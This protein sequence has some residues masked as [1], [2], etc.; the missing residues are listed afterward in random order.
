VTWFKDRRFNKLVNTLKF[1]YPLMPSTGQSSAD[2]ASVGLLSSELR[3]LTPED[4]GFNYG[5]LLSRE[6]CIESVV[7]RFRREVLLYGPKPGK[8]K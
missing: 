6:C 2:L 4:K 1:V 7:T 3:L 8:K 5:Y